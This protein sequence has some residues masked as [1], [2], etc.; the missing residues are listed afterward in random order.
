MTTQEIGALVQRFRLTNLET[1]AFQLGNSTLVR[2]RIPDR[3]SVTTVV[4]ALETDAN[5]LF[6]QPNY[7]FALIQ[8]PLR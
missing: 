5:V 7:L 8:E 4:R 1:T 3:R 6:A 2:L